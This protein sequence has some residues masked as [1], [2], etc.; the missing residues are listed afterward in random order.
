M[1]HVP[2]YAI[3]LLVLVGACAPVGTRELHDVALFEPDG[4]TRYRYVYGSADLL[5][6]DGVDRQLG[7]TVGDAFD[8]TAQVVAAA[9]IVDGA[10]FLR[11]TSEET[12]DPPL[13]VGRIPLTTDLRLVTT[14]AVERSYYFDGDRWFELPRD[15]AAGVTRTVVP[16]PVSKPFRGAASL[17]P[18]EA[19]A[20]AA[21]LG[22]G[23]IA[24]VVAMVPS[25]RLAGETPHPFAA[26][27][28][29]GLDEYRYSAFWIQERLATDT[30][31]YEPPPER[32]IFDVVARGGQGAAPL[33]DRFEVL[34]DEDELRTFWNAVQADAFAPAPLPEL[35]FDRETVLAIRLAE[36]PTG[37]YAIDVA[38]VELDDD[39][40]FVDVVLREPAA[41]AVVTQAVTSPWVLVRV[42]GTEATVV[43]FRDPDSGELFAVAR[44]VGS[45]F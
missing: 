25:A 15:L 27:A 43:W 42:L 2:L 21:R 32:F 36:R 34:T 5:P 44:G 33:R 41:D 18:A 29:E 39:E 11:A 10:P 23:G 8:D 22:A 6:L 4:A 13:E 28:P 14:A 31:A 26:S 9:R 19:D 1:R 17:T 20:L 30:D 12:I 40:L 35:R 38:G 37:G 7:R 45:T 3:L 16:V 24:R